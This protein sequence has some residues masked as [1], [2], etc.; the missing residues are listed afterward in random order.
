M[1]LN[2]ASDVAYISISK[3]FEIMSFEI[4]S[5]IIAAAVFA[6]RGRSAYGFGKLCSYIELSGIL[7]PISLK[8]MTV[9]FFLH[10]V[11]MMTFIS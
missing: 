1:L 9:V 8:P 4:M 5:F 3:A 7:N 10:Q 2:A 6:I 11:A